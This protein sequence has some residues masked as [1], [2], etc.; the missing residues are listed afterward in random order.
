MV[1]LVV[2]MLHAN[3]SAPEKELLRWHFHLGH[4]GF[5]KVQF[6]NAPR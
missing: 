2:S 3:L 4:L 1:M 6:L 5:W